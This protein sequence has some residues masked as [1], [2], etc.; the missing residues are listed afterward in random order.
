MSQIK[1][2]D[3]YVSVDFMILEIEG[4]TWTPNILGR[5]FLATE[6]RI[7][8]KNG[9]LSFDVGDDHV[10]LNL[11]K[12]SKLP[13]IFEKYHMIDVVD[14]LE[15]EAISNLESDDPLKYCMLNDST[16]SDENPEVEMCAQFLE[17]S[18]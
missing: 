9:K 10:E 16:T 6:R 14:S 8:V 5:P 15:W 1:V 18:P 4:D 2:G 7:D 11:F 17:A 12:A 3:L 13:S